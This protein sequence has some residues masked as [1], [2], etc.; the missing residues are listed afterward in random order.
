MKI[1]VFILV[2]FHY[3]SISQGFD[4]QVSVRKPFSVPKLYLGAFI[5]YDNI[6]YS[7]NFDLSENGTNCC[8]YESG[9]GRGLGVGISSEYWWRYNSTLGISLNFN[10]QNALFQNS[11]AI[12]SFFTDTTIFKYR[13]ENVTYLGSL[14]LFGKYRI[15]KKLN[16][17]AELQVLFPITEKINASQDITEQSENDRTLSRVIQ[18][19]NLPEL[20]SIVIV[21]GINISYDIAIAYPVYISPF[22]AFNFNI[23]SL[24]SE[25]LSYFQTRIGFKVFSG[26]G[27]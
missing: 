27:L 9:N 20:S 6:S 24:N 25:D 5:S 2:L 7:G 1:L 8:N 4:W 19:P 14:S 17:G 22:I 11:E 21:P 23:N 18:N 3:L 26:L 13:L 15:F 10:Q 12:P 16:I